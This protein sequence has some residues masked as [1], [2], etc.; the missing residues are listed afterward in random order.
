MGKNGQ[1]YPFF[2]QFLVKNA[3]FDQNWPSP[4]LVPK[5][6]QKSGTKNDRFLVKNRLPSRVLAHFWSK[7]EGTNFGAKIDQN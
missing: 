6:R 7:I 3:N 1:I 2:D 4:I 5:S